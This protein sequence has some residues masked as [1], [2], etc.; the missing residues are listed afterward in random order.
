MNQ[1]IN[2]SLAQISTPSKGSWLGRGSATLWQTSQS[3]N[4][5]AKART[6]GFLKIFRVPKR[7]EFPRN[8]TANQLGRTTSTSLSS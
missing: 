7:I 6:P 3:L 8:Q 1:P 5:S 4:S 2:R